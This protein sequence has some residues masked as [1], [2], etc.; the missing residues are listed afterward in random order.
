MSRDHPIEHKFITAPP[1]SQCITCHTHPGTTVMNSY[2][3]FMWWDEETDSELMYPKKAKIPDFTSR[4]V[5]S[6]PP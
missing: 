6:R 4:T 5:A 1:S 3:G 2:L